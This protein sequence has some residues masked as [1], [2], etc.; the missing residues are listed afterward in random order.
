[1]G[2]IQAEVMVAETGGGPG[3]ETTGQP[4]RRQESNETSIYGTE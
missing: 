1:M 4:W 3:V 2:I